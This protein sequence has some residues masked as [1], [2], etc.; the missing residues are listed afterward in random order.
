MISVRIDSVG[1]GCRV[2]GVPFLGMCPIRY[3]V[4]NNVQDIQGIQVEAGS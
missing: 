3:R 2:H 1:G 4:R